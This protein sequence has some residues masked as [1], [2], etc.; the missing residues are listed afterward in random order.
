M[1]SEIERRRHGRAVKMLGHPSDQRKRV[2]GLSLIATRK[3]LASRQYLTALSLIASLVLA[4]ATAHAETVT[5]I[6]A[7][8]VPSPGS[9]IPGGAGSDATVCRQS[10]SDSW[11]GNLREC[12]AHLV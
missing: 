4:S 10:I 11:L 7:N 12:L 9:P 5:V 2:S 3:F 8:G 6:G 1:K